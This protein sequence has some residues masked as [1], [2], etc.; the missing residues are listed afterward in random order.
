MTDDQHA[1]DRGHDHV[2]DVG[3]ARFTRRQLLVGAAVFSLSATPV[4][5]LLA[6]NAVSAPGRGS[7]DP[8]R[9]APLAETTRPCRGASALDSH[10]WKRHGTVL[11]PDQR[12]ELSPAGWGSIAE[13][14]LVKDANGWHLWYHSGDGRAIGMGYATADN[15]IGPWKKH[16]PSLA[17]APV[18]NP[19]FETDSDSDG[20]ADGWTLFYNTVTAPVLSL[21]AG[22]GGG[23]AQRIQYTLQPADSGK[24]IWLVQ[25]VAAGI[26][27]NETVSASLWVK[28]ALTGGCAVFV[29]PVL[30]GRVRRRGTT[31]RRR[32][33]GNMSWAQTCRCVLASGE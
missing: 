3:D 29:D 16:V 26:T 27:Q 17:P 24:T 20:L 2:E 22:R 6:G 1:E 9:C 5:A 10:G 15:A 31:S 8:A 32:V 28:G 33:L 30:L 18:V 23:H 7:R 4:G 19:S 21:V 13:S 12:W 14:C 25:T 11:V